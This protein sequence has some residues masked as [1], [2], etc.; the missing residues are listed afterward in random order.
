MVSETGPPDAGAATVRISKMLFPDTPRVVYNTN[1]LDEVIC[2]LRFPPI[3]RIGVDSPAG[4]QERIRKNYPQYAQDADSPELP[5]EL[6]SLLDGLRIPNPWGRPS[7]LKHTFSTNDDYRSVVITAG[8]LALADKNYKLWEEFRSEIS[9]LEAEFRREYEPDLYT[10][11][12]LRYRDRITRSELKLDKV[13]WHDL[14]NRELI[15]LLGSK[16]F[17]DVIRLDRAEVQLEIP[18]IEDGRLHLRLGLASAK[19]SAEMS[20]LIDTDL[21]TS[22]RCTN[23][24]ALQILDEFHTI[25]GNFFRWA[26]SDKLRDALGPRQLGDG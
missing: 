24:D 1:V 11:I 14:L 21:Y 23:D 15:G 5:R 7:S 17:A 10:R 12:G 3:L 19:D 18:E 16:P 2:Q 20:Y 22:K 9:F 26:I 8:F 25:G 4:F 13:G 6:S